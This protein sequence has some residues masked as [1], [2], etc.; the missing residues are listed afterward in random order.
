[1]ETVTVPLYLQTLFVRKSGLTSV[2]ECLWSL[3]QG[4]KSLHDDSA[5][6]D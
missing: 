2:T 3:C 1:M 5:M 4:R 6:C